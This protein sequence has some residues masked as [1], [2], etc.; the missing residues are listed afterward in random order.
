MVNSR[1]TF[2]LA[3]LPWLA[4][5]GLFSSEQA[6]PDAV[7]IRDARAAESV[8]WTRLAGA[9]LA[10][11]E[12]PR[13]G[14]RIGRA[15]VEQN[16]EDIRLAILVQDLELQVEDPDLVRRR[17]MT[18]WQEEPS[19]LHAFLAAR[20][21][22]DPEK[23]FFLLGKALELSPGMTQ[24]RVYRIFMEARAGEPEVLD[25]LIAV[26]NEDPGSAEA[27]R[28]LGDLAPLYGRKDLA[29]AA[30]QTEPWSMSE[31]PSR[32]A[33]SLA[34]ADLQAGDPRAALVQA[35]NL[36]G[37]HWEGRLLEAAAL[38]A[39]DNPAEALVIVESVLAERPEEPAALFNKALLLREY[40]GRVGEARV[41][42][43]KFLEVSAAGGS[44]NLGRVMQAELWL[45]LEDG[46]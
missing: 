45:S 13:G 21:R 37:G 4:S 40:L 35:R 17:A 3:A 33:Y 41:I 6:L 15:L 19:G 42:L 34:V 1:L 9:L 29:R 14:L 8:S 18:A 23:R 39:L 5:C 16:P 10:F 25:E 27:W 28:L 20:T 38:A 44:S 22:Q 30:A 43:E 24:A 31:D 2:A 12:D 32:A 36:P 7:L 11:Q 26:L 46:A